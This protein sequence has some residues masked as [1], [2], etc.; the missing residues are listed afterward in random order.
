MVAS[1]IAIIISGLPKQEEDSDLTSRFPFL[2]ERS[3]ADGNSF[4][5][6][7][8]TTNSLIEDLQLLV[9]VLPMQ[10]GAAKKI[11]ATAHRTL[12]ASQL[13]VSL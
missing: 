4:W 6:H 2:L 10:E 7:I 12:L 11:T 8:W 5:A 1:K 13:L 9:T 3:L